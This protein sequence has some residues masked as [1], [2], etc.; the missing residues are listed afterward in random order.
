MI[1]SSRMS[2]Y[3]VT[4][5]LLQNLR[6]G[7]KK[8]MTEKNKLAI[9]MVMETLPSCTIKNITITLILQCRSIICT[10]KN[11]NFFFFTLFFTYRTV[12]RVFTYINYI[13]IYTFIILSVGRF[14]SKK[15]KFIIFLSALLLLYPGYLYHYLQIYLSWLFA[16]NL[17][18]SDVKV[19]TWMEIKMSWNFPYS[20]FDNL[21]FHLIKKISYYFRNNL[22]FFYAEFSVIYNFS[23]LKID[24]L[25][26]R[27]D[28]SIFNNS[29]NR[30]S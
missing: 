23:F 6:S 18:S 10:H 27:F 28:V 1:Y 2:R 21:W 11:S 19:Y 17:N 29:A 8:K 14:W 7:K 20:I 9:Y 16:F 26:F 12:L 4:Y 30:F 13:Y 24:F 22:I 3:V 25:K 5:S 15:K